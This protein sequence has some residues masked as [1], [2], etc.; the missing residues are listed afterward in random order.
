MSSNFRHPRVTLTGRRL[1]KAPLA[2]VSLPVHLPRA[3]FILPHTS[4]SSLPRRAV[5]PPLL[6]GQPNGPSRW[7]PRSSGPSSNRKKFRKFPS[8]IFSVSWTPNNAKMKLEKRGR[9]CM[10]STFPCANAVFVCLQRERPFSRIREERA[11]KDTPRLFKNSFSRSPTTRTTTPTG[12][13]RGVTKPEGLAPADADAEPN[14]G[15]RSADA[16]VAAGSFPEGGGHGSGGRG[17]RPAGLRPLPAR[18]ACKISNP[19]QVKS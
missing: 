12:V 14:G 3:P 17:G 13:A 8:T 6:L 2:R 15:R 18:R 4:L 7:S 5:P 10:T 1:S 19:L 11:G 16:R 9:A